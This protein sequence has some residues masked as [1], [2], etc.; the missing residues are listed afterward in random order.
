MQRDRVEDVRK[1]I[2]AELFESLSS[3]NQRRAFIAAQTIGSSLQ[4]PIGARG[5]NDSWTDE[6]TETLTRLDG[7]LDT[8]TV[9][10]PVLVRVAESVHWHAFYG[11]ERTQETAKRIVARLDRDIETQTV[12][13]LIDA[14][15][16][17]TRLIKAE[18]TRSPHEVETAAL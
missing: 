11:P 9:S 3:T 10:A 8:V 17:N 7:L 1:Q 13:N 14:W 18:A 4:G 15:G 12:R 2:V 16:L 6:F 5:G